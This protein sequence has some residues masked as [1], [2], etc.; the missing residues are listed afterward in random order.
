MAGTGDRAHLVSSYMIVY[1]IDEVE[2]VDAYADYTQKYWWLSLVVGILAILY[3]AFLFSYRDLSL[4]LFAV[5]LGAFLVGW[6]ILKTIDAAANPDDRW[7]HVVISLIVIGAGVLTL[8]WPEITL[9]VLEIVLAWF[10][11]IWGI[12]DLV[13]SISNTDRDW[14]WL[15]LIRGI[16]LMGLGCWALAH[17]GGTLR[18]FVAIFGIAVV[19][20][21]I[22]DVIGAFHLRKFKSRW[23]RQ[24][25]AAGL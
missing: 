15:W 18:L 9:R 21:G 20:F 4:F 8:V 17:P 10:L 16:I 23:E 6:G 1:E 2:L 25:R 13:R 11:V 14:W 24:K 19:V 3:G 5:F 22:V 12:V 7:L